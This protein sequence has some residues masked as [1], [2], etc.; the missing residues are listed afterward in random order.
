MTSCQPRLL[1]DAMHGTRSARLRVLVVFTCVPSLWSIVLIIFA[2]HPSA[3]G[4]AI[5][6]A[7]SARQRVLLVFTRL[8]SLTSR[9]L[10]ELALHSS[11]LPARARRHVWDSLCAPARARGP[12]RAALVLCACSLSYGL[13][14]V[15]VVCVCSESRD[16]FRAPLPF[17]RGLI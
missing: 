11:A 17:G 6:A 14:C 9:V 3:L 16:F 12:L 7:C 13:M 4:N 5:I 8:P 1:R 10:I 2:L 15:C